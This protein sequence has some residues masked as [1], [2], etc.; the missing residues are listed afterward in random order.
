M[1]TERE[2]WVLE[3]EEMQLELDAYRAHSFNAMF[4]AWKMSC[5]V[6]RTREIPY[7]IREQA[8]KLNG[9]VQAILEIEGIINL[10]G[11]TR[12]C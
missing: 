11:E 2:S 9:C 10:H 6:M 7:E 1:S 12:C 4:D 5:R 3:G 8:A